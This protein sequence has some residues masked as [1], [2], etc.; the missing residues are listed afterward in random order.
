MTKPGLNRRDHE[1]GP[2]DRR[3]DA[4]GTRAHRM[5]RVVALAALALTACSAPMTDA[6]QGTTNATAL[7]IE[8]L[9][10]SAVAL[11]GLSPL[12]AQDIAQAKLPGELACGFAD[13]NEST[14]VYASGNAQ[15]DED[16]I[17]L[18]N[19]AASVERLAAPGGFDALVRGPTFTGSGVR[20]EI[21]IKDGPSVSG[22]SPPRPAFLTVARDG[23]PDARIDG[24][25]TCG[26]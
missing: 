15:S 10:G 1:Q 20:V 12:T 2:L 25:W 8:N 19:V 9:A 14:L 7:P 24:T 21:A 5:L 3:I 6:E 22:E 16:A 13:H 18:I 26:P 11:H 4:R 23:K 17:G